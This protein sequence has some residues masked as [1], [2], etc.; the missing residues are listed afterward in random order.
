MRKTIPDIQKIMT[1]MEAHPLAR[2]WAVG[3]GCVRG[4]PRVFEKA[5]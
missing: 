3:R 5:A 2:R 4:M 1:V